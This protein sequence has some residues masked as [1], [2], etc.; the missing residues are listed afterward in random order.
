MKILFLDIDGVLN[1]AGFVK[2]LSARKERLQ[3]DGYGG[4][5]A[6]FDPGAIKRLNR[7]IGE[8]EARVVLSSTWR[9]RW[10]I[11]DIQA[12]LEARGG[13]MGEIID[14][15]PVIGMER[16][17]GAEI[18]RWLEETDRSVESFVILDD[19]SD[20]T[21]HE[22]RLVQTSFEAGGLQDTHVE[23]AIEMFETSDE[24]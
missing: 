17:R 5:S 20:M 23:K 1:S 3:T 9:I 6:W 11:E 16:C 13:F 7:I 22:D 21:P 2:D 14:K 12:I 18:N 19:D 4:H 15:T 24:S 10:D 8:T